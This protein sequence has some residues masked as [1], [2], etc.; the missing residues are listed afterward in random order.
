M[1]RVFGHPLKERDRGSAI[2]R[3]TFASAT[4]ND[5]SKRRRTHARVVS[6][7]LNVSVLPHATAITT[8]PDPPNTLTLLYH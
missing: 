7:I 4:D 6:H 8:Q 1:R 5:L 3:Q 2:D